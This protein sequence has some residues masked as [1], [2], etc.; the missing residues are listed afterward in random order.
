MRYDSCFAS[1]TWLG[2]RTG[3]SAGSLE[4]VSARLATG[5]GKWNCPGEKVVR[6]D[7]GGCRAISRKSADFQYQLLPELWATRVQTGGGFLLC[8]YPPL[9]GSKRQRLGRRSKAQGRKGAK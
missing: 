5:R 1:A 2:F 6:T 3:T 8:T 4:S 7:E 9:Q